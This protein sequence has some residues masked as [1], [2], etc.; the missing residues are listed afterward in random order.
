MK[1]QIELED[2]D[3]FFIYGFLHGHQEKVKNID[4]KAFIILERV[5]KELLKSMKG[6]ENDPLR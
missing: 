1:Y 2:T 5:L 4:D 6:H 3:C